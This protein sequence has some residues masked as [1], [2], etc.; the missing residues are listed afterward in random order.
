MSQLSMGV[1]L[2]MLSGNSETVEALNKVKG[3]K[4][5]VIT[6]VQADPDFVEISTRDHTIRISDQGQ[7]CCERRYMVTDDSLV[8]FIGAKILGFELREAPS[9][10]KTEA[11]DEDHEVQFLVILTDKGNI[12]FS[13]HNEHNGYYGGFSICASVVED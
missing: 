2:N 4:I 1:M 9:P 3:K 11:Y 6:L 8:Q 7:S 10:T 5:K 12:T 13:N